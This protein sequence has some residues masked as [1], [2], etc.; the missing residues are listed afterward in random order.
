MGLDK[1]TGHILYVTTLPLVS[2]W[3]AEQPA[4]TRT[5]PAPVWLDGAYERDV[6]P[7]IVSQ[8]TGV[9]PTVERL[10]IHAQAL[11]LHQEEF[12]WD[13]RTVVS[14]SE[15]ESEKFQVLSKNINQPRKS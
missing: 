2:D 1:N 6:T 8:S 3:K 12:K 13:T 10:G 11:Q 7:Y 14:S 9:P 5:P 4:N 15:T